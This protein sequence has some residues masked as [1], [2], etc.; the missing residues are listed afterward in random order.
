MKKEENEKLEVMIVTSHK[1][2]CDNN[3]DLV[4]H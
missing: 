2:G 1:G 4:N 3:V